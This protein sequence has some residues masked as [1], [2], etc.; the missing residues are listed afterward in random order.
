VLRSYLKAEG[1][2]LLFNG[3]I[4]TV[5]AVGCLPARCYSRQLCLSVLAR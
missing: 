2:S 1:R 5:G 3:W 4:T